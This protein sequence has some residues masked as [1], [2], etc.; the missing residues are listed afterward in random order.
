MGEATVVIFGG[1]GVVGYSVAEHLSSTGYFRPRIADIREP[2]ELKPNMEY[3]GCDVRNRQAV[4]RALKGADVALNMAIIQ[5]PDINERR[6]LAYE[7]NILGTINICEAVAKSPTVKGMIQAGS[8]H[9]F[10]DVELRGII[11]ESFG[12]RPDKVEPRA[13][14]YALH[15]VGQEVLVR[16]FD[17]MCEKPFCVV[18]QGTVLGKRMPVKA[19]AS[20]FIEQALRGGP[21]TPYKHSA[22]RPMLFAYLGDVCKAFETLVE[23]VLDGSLRGQGDSLSKVV[24]ICYPESMTVLE[25]AQMVCELVAELT[26]GRL[27][28]EVQIVNK[29]LPS[30]FSSEEKLKIHVDVSRTKELLGL[31]RLT[32][33]RE[34]LREVIEARLTAL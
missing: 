24:N 30:L 7:V 12:F 32:S 22:H 6:R 4:E 21:V 15:K 31:S 26:N 25:L 2:P 11:D 28:P 16:I 1:S 17:E 20:I 14:L 29:G 33:P 13:R 18:R 23:K 8:W 9:V 34:A 10:G 5:I 19:A 27:R 3:V